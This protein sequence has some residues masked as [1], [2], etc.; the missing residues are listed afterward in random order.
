MRPAVS[1]TRIKV[2][3]VEPD[4]RHPALRH[5]NESHNLL[6]HVG[7]V[8][9]IRYRCGTKAYLLLETLEVHAFLR[10]PC[11]FHRNGTGFQCRWDMHSLAIGQRQAGASGTEIVPVL[12]IVADSHFYIKIIAAF[13]QFGF[14]LIYL[15]LNR[16][17]GGQT[18]KRT[19]F[20]RLGGS[21]GGVLSQEIDFTAFHKADRAAIRELQV[22]ALQRQG[23]V[24]VL[25]PDIDSKQQQGI[26]LQGLG[27]RAE[28]L[29]SRD[30]SHVGGSVLAYHGFKAWLL[31]A[32]DLLEIDRERTVFGRGTEAHRQAAY[33]CILVRNNGIEMVVVH[34][35]AIVD[36]QNVVIPLS[37][38]RIENIDMAEV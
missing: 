19:H 1:V 35:L 16:M 13:R 9:R 7:V 17:L 3:K 30:K 14:R 2:E 33:Q 38:V 29:V 36:F 23:I 32:G 28:E 4:L 26:A 10:I 22:K 12:G 20:H 8:S 24:Q 25:R 5:G 37:I 21:E 18:G 31:E 11:V 15:N 6:A 27:C 34:T